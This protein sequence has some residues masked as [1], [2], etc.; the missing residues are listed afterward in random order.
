[1][2]TACGGWSPTVRVGA[3]ETGVKDQRY[4]VMNF[5]PDSLFNV[6]RINGLTKADDCSHECIDIAADYGVLVLHITRLRYLAITFKGYLLPA[7]RTTA[8]SS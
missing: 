8:P 1:M 5:I 4:W 6:R 7:E 3:L 2:G